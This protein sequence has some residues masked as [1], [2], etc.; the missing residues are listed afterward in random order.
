MY[1]WGRGLHVTPV[2]YGGQKT[3][4]GSELPDVSESGPLWE[5]GVPRTTELFLQQPL[6]NPGSFLLEGY[7]VLNV[8]A[9]A[10]NP[11]A[12]ESGQEDQEFKA[13]LSYIWSSR[14]NW[15]T[16]DRCLNNNKNSGYASLIFGSSLKKVY[17]ILLSFCIP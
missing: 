13:S 1:V 17:F 11:S 4:S 16:W 2:A 8:M 12:Q 9:P 15:A 3:N 6:P 7:C 10:C 14:G 5:Q